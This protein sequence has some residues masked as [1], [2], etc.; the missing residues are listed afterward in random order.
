[1]YVLFCAVIEIA[2]MKSD[3]DL[4]KIFMLDEP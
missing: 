3:Y 1:M 4:T 2:R